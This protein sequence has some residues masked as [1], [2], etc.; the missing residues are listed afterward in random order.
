ME[1][2]VVLGAGVVRRKCGESSVQGLSDEGVWTLFAVNASPKY[3][4][5]GSVRAAGMFDV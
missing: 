5:D 3:P 1:Y 2:K 4:H